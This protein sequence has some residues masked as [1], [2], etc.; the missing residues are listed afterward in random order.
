MAKSTKHNASHI[1]F[2]FCHMA[3]LNKDLFLSLL[4]DSRYEEYCCQLV[5][6]LTEV[7]SDHAWKSRLKEEEREFL[8][9]H[10]FSMSLQVLF[11]YMQQLN[12]LR[13]KDACLY[14]RKRGEGD[15][16]DV[17]ELVMLLRELMAIF[18]P[19]FEDT[20]LWFCPLRIRICVSIAYLFLLRCRLLLTMGFE[21]DASLLLHQMLSLLEV[22]FLFF[23]LSLAPFVSYSHLVHT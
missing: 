20:L 23:F 10:F 6:L 17:G 1:C 15:P 13:R 22:G 4:D 21:E 9:K 11:S 19:S 3:V 12:S 14:K 5:A 8:T 18:S 7:R 2:F 16:V